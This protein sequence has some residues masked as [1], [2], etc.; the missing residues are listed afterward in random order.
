MATERG[1]VWLEGVVSPSRDEMVYLAKMKREAREQ[2]EKD[3]KLLDRHKDRKQRELERAAKNASEEAAKQADAAAKQATAT[4][5][6]S[7]AV[8]KQVKA[9]TQAFTAQVE[10]AG[11]YIVGGLIISGLLGALFIWRR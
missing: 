4:V 10:S 2:K 3:R 7:E 11:P 8:S 9:E 1:E 5:T 6:T